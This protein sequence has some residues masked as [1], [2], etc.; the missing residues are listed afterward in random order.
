MGE[1]NQVERMCKLNYVLEMLIKEGKREEKR[2]PPLCVS[3]RC[4]CVHH[5]GRR[6][7][8]VR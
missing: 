7:R 4:P 5:I 1:A 6:V 3:V 2:P 8:W